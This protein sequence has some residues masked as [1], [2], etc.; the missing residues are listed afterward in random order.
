[1]KSVGY[2]KDGDAIMVDKGFNIDKKISSLGLKLN[3]PPFASVSR[4]I[5]PSE[6]NL[7]NKIAKHRVYVER[8]ICKVT[9]YKIL[10]HCIP[11]SLFEKVNEIFSVCCHLTLF[12]DV[13][14]KDKD[15]NST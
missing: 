8:L 2:V 6:I 5:S 12:P 1:M 14:V 11:T 4:Q 13:F 10:S 15:G 3:I 7:T 9:T